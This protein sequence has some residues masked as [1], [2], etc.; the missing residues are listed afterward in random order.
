VEATTEGLNRWLGKE[1]GTKEPVHIETDDADL[2][3]DLKRGLAELKGKR[4][5]GEI[6]SKEVKPGSGI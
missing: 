5:K 6:E 3:A 2:P 1:S 4:R